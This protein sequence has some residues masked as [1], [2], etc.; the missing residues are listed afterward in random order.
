M[1]LQ[2]TFMPAPYLGPCTSVYCSPQRNLL[3][4]KSPDA[5]RPC[6][7]GRLLS[8]SPPHTARVY[9]PYS[10]RLPVTAR[11]PL[12]CSLLPPESQ[13]LNRIIIILYWSLPLY[14]NS[15]TPAS[16]SSLY[17]NSSLLLWFFLY[18]EG[19]PHLLWPPLCTNAPLYDHGPQSMAIDYPPLE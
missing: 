15:A 9:Y 5:C 7:Q 8:Q 13:P 11:V 17:S 1:Y 18:R 6:Q 19:A 3:C 2:V 10:K 16:P 12:C 14:T 4:S